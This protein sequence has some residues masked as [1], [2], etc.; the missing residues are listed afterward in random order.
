MVTNIL[1]GNLSQLKQTDSCQQQPRTFSVIASFPC[2]GV[3]LEQD[4]IL[5]TGMCAVSGSR[6]ISVAVENCGFA[7]VNGSRSLWYRSEMVHK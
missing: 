2:P 5:H 3:R 7:V 1:V 4:L 6:Y